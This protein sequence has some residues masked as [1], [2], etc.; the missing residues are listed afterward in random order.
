MPGLEHRLGQQRQQR[1]DATTAAPSAM[2]GT[3]MA[4]ARRR[5][6]DGA[7][8]PVLHGRLVSRR[9]REVSADGFTP[10][11]ALLK[12][13]LVNSAV[14]HDGHHRHPGQ[15]PGLGPRA[16]GE[17]ALLHRPSARKL[18]VKDDA[19]GFP[20]GSTDET[21][22]YNFTVGAGEPL[23]GHAGLDRLPLDAGREPAPQQRPRPDR[24][25]PRRRL[26]GQRLLGRRS[27]R[28]AAAADRRNTLEQVLLAAPAPGTLQ[29]TVR[30]FNVPNG[31]QPFA[32]VVTGNVTAGRAAADG[33]ALTPPVSGLD[34]ARRL[35]AR[36]AGARS[37]SRAPASAPPPASPTS[38]ARAGSGRATRP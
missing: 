31:P 23:Q 6:P 12:A 36:R 3:S 24:H 20:P 33:R 9:A 18:W 35:L 10:S 27:R 26:P 4:V 38:A 7:H 30:R 37:P 19:T 8:P 15:L 16:A 14:Q 28:P 25:R 34:T 2:R 1:H 5:R 13:T 29:V 22:T 21:R 17:R 11:A 32:L